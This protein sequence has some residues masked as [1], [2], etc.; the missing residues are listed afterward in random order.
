[1]NKVNAAKYNVSV[2]TLNILFKKCIFELN[3]SVIPTYHPSAHNTN[4]AKSI[5]GGLKLNLKMCSGSAV[6]TLKG[7]PSGQAT[8]SAKQGPRKVRSTLLHPVNPSPT[9]HPTC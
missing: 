3:L 7:F 1:M 8:A 4:G 6:T 9:H 5:R 2:L